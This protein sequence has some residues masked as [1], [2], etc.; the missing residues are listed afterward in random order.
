MAAKRD[1]DSAGGYPD[2][3][4]GMLGGTRNTGGGVPIGPREDRAPAYKQVNSLPERDSGGR[5]RRPLASP[6][7]GRVPCGLRQRFTVMQ[8]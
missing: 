3:G 5:L 8:I 1:V 2:S 4:R 6:P 7:R